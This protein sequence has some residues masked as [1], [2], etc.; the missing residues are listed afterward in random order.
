M[1]DIVY[2]RILAANDDE[3][4]VTDRSEGNVTMKFVRVK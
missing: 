2:G 4:R 1:R 3:E